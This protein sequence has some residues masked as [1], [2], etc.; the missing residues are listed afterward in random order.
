MDHY[1]I[2]RTPQ[3]PIAVERLLAAIFEPVKCSVPSNLEYERAIEAKR[4]S[5]HAAAL[6]VRQ[7]QADDEYASWHITE[8]KRSGC[9]C[10][11]WYSD[12]IVRG[13]PLL[14]LGGTL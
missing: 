14:G 3:T 10:I 5:I 8:P 6:A 12:Q 9:Q 2:Q 4:H 13:A 7:A 1:G 11:D